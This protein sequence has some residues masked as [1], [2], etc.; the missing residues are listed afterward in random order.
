ML[1]VR[2]ESDLSLLLTNAT[3]SS[4]ILPLRKVTL[5]TKPY[6]PTTTLSYYLFDF[7]NSLQI[8][9][10]LIHL[11]YWTY[12]ALTLETAVHLLNLMKIV[13]VYSSLARLYEEINTQIMTTVKL[14]FVVRPDNSFLSRNLVFAINLFF[15]K[16]W[17]NI[18][19]LSNS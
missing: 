14:F 12:L 5:M 10:A 2:L 17:F 13:A 3:L 15:I 7:C 1:I 11:R 4:V 9:F 16:K 19:V 18:Y 6:N 8:S